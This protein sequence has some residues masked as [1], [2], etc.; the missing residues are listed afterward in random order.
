[1]CQV[2]VCELPELFKGARTRIDDVPSELQSRVTYDE[3]KQKINERIWD[4]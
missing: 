1:M 2:Q 4:N 3:V